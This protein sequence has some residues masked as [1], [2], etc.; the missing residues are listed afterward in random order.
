MDGNFLDIPAL[1]GFS[2]PT[3]E[4]T[5]T[6]CMQGKSFGLCKKED[7]TSRV[8]LLHKAALPM[9]LPKSPHVRSLEVALIMRS[10][11]LPDRR[12]RFSRIIERDPRAM[13]VHD[14][15]FNGTV[16][17]MST[18]ESEIPINCR[19]RTSE[20]CPSFGWVIRYC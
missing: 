20:K 11:N 12:R 1:L 9:I 16:E 7:I 18:N 10:H 17:N 6:A 13:V 15:G 2:S 3:Q 8:F 14:M 4:H 5:H 19:G